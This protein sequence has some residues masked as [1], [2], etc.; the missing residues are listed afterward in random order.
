MRTRSILG[1]SVIT[2]ALLA[3]SV[4]MATPV[5]PSGPI[6]I[7]QHDQETLVN[8]LAGLNTLKGF[9]TISTITDGGS[10]TYFNQGTGGFLYDV[11]SGFT[12]DNANTHAIG[13]TQ[14]QIALTGGTLNYYYYATDQAAAINSAMSLGVD[15]VLNQVANG[16]GSLLWLSLTPQADTNGDTF[17]ITLTTNN[18]ANPTGNGLGFADVTGAGQADLFLH[19]CKEPDATSGPTNPSTPAVTA[20]PQGFTDF[21]FVGGSNTNRGA[22]AALFPVSGTDHIS[23]TVGVPEPMTLSLFGAGLIGA[24][25]FG[26]RKAKKA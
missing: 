21:T 2:A 7:D 4:A 5:V 15:G 9:G 18:P 11:F 13:T 1:L 6:E 24:F 16:A 26:R 3:S 12:V 22:D 19:T 8:P 17:I 23:G 10:N 25:A 20:C 14:F